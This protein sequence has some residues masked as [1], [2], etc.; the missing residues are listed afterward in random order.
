MNPNSRSPWADWFRFMKSMSISDQGSSRLNCVCRCS[1]G[2]CSAP[3]P[4]IHIFAGEN[5]CI[6]AITPTQRLCGVRLEADLPD[7]LR[8]LHD[9]LLHHADRD[10][11]LGVERAGDLARVLVD[12][13]ER[14]L[15]VQLLAPGQEPDFVRAQRFP[16]R[17]R[18]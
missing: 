13:A 8:A 4:P 18:A 3:R 6:Q 16:G 5:V 2:F 14:L 15:A 1:S 17:H 11:R 7:R 10:R 12:L 9:G